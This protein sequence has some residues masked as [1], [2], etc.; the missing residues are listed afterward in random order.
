[1]GMEGSKIKVTKTGFQLIDGS[2][3]PVQIWSI[4]FNLV[5][6]DMVGFQAKWDHIRNQMMLY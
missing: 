3:P 1:M 6:S 5:K 4:T 2:V